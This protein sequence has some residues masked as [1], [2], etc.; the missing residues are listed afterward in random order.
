MT[1]SLTAKVRSH[2]NPRDFELI[3]IFMASRILLLELRSSG[4]LSPAMVRWSSME[5]MPQGEDF[6]DLEP[7][8]LKTEARPEVNHLNNS[9]LKLTLKIYYFII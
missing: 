4:V 5:L 3:I 8:E 7:A 2:F 1:S 6:E 9:F